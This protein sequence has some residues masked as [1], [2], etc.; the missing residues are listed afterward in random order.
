MADFIQKVLDRGINELCDELRER[1]S[2]HTHLL[3][4]PNIESPLEA[5]FYALWSM[6]GQLEGYAG[7]KFILEPQVIIAS[8]YRVDF[9]VKLARCD[10]LARLDTFPLVCVE[11]DGHQFH[12]TTKE[13]ATR[14]N[15]RDRD[16]TAAGWKMFRFSGSEFYRSPL[17]CV[18]EV[19]AFA[20][21]AVYDMLAAESRSQRGAA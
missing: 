9:Q 8:A 17:G 10:G 6:H 20:C 16:I 19:D 5:A 7:A 4:N 13:Q 14:R 12:E 3:Q 1:C 18:Q 15:T 2:G 21:D 11:L